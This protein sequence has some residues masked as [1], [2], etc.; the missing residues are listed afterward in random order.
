LTPPASDVAE[1]PIM[2]LAPRQGGQAARL[3][4]GGVPAEQATQGRPSWIGPAFPLPVI[5]CRCPAEAIW[6]SI[7]LVPAAGRGTQGLG[8]GAPGRAGDVEGDV[9]NVEGDVEGDV[10]NGEVTSRTAP[11]GRGSPRR[12]GA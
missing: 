1:V 12:S 9:Q 2:D 3:D 10:E 5:L 4:A 8:L 7:A 11:A 6:G